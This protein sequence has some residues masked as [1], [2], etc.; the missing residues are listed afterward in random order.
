MLLQRLAEYAASHPGVSP[1]FHRER[2]YS[3]Q[4]EL[5]GTGDLQSGDLTPLVTTQAARRPP[6][7]I[8]HTT[9]STVRTTQVAA[10]LA[11]DDIQY[12]L[13]WADMGSNPDRITSCHEA[14]IK[15]TQRWVDS[16]AGQDDPVAQAV[17]AFYRGDAGAGVTRPN[18]FTPKQGVLIAVDGKPAYTASSVVPFWTSEV[19]IRKGRTARGVCLVCAQSAPLLDTMPGKVPA[20]LIPGASNDAALV[21]INERVFGYDLS[22]QLTQTPLC[23]GCGDRVTAGLTAALASPHAVSYPNQD[24]RL[25]WWVTETND[26]DAMELLNQPDPDEVTGWLAAV[27]TGRTVSTTQDVTMFCSLTVGGNGARIMVRDWVEMPIADLHRNIVAWFSDTEIVPSQRKPPRHQALYPLLLCTGRWRKATSQ[28]SGSFTELGAKGADRPAT[29]QRDLLRAAICG[30]PI[31]PSLLTHVIRR[32]RGDG[33]LD[34]RRAS[35]IRLGLIRSFHTTEN[36]MPDLDP[37]NIDPAYIAGRAF[38]ELEHIQDD[39]AGRERPN[40]TYGDRYFSGAVIN[41]RAAL[42]N[43]RRDAN[44]WLRKLRR[45][46]NGVAIKHEQTLDQLFAMIDSRLGLPTRTTLRQQ[47][48][49]LLG[50]HHQRARRF[51]GHPNPTEGNPARAAGTDIPTK[52]EIA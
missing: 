24:S 43:G 14:F 35:L 13:G 49:F 6:R 23:L 15:L 18:M 40:T 34:D 39:S 22:L 46:R 11:A 32:V 3:W 33:H 41:P 36:H 21:S 50:Y 12:V 19:A 51:A 4:L 5:T 28:R 31:P 7:G 29:A 44:A 8:P 10:N 26:F 27:R 1:P 17:A 2:V 25:T 30:A 45:S 16:D 52:N 20:N 38:A 37:T 48:A 42:I 9:P 47:G